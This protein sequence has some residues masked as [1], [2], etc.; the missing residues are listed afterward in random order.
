MAALDN[1]ICG[2]GNL[3]IA[4]GT[5]ITYVKSYLPSKRRM[6]QDEKRIEE[7]FREMGYVG[8]I[9]PAPQQ[10]WFGA[11]CV[12]AIILNIGAGLNNFHVFHF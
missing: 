6:A 10:K 8:Y 9:P 11:F 3:V 2:I 5:A 12:I 7:L 1:I 4:V